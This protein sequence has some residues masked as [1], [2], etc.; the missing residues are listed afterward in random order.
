MR[1]SVF[2][3]GNMQDRNR[4][5]IERSCVQEVSEANIRE[6]LDRTDI[7]IIKTTNG[8]AVAVTDSPTDFSASGNSY[9]S[10]LETSSAAPSIASSSSASPAS[11]APVIAPSTVSTSN[12]VFVTA[13][14]VTSGVTAPAAKYRA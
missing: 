3:S 6:Q 4:M 13:A 10:A 7:T 5:G 14:V 11:A 2:T 8:W 9:P 1:E 12:I